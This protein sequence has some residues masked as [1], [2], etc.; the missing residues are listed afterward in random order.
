MWFLLLESRRV[1]YTDGELFSIHRISERLM[2]SFQKVAKKKFWCF[3]SV[4]VSSLLCRFVS[5]FNFALFI[6]MILEMFNPVCFCINTIIMIFSSRRLTQNKQKKQSIIS[7]NNHKNEDNKK[8]LEILHEFL[9][10]QQ[11]LFYLIS[12]VTFSML[13]KIELYHIYCVVLIFCGALGFVLLL[14]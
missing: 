11:Y 1:Q 8:W 7:L 9:S 4:S 2:T 13:C 5:S 10:F 12:Y 14:S 3:S 6:C